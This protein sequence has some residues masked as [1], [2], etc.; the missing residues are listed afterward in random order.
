MYKINT[1]NPISLLLSFSGVMSK[2]LNVAPVFFS[3][4]FFLKETQQNRLSTF[5]KSELRQGVKGSRLWQMW[6]QTHLAAAAARE[7]GRSWWVGGGG[8]GGAMKWS[9]RGWQMSAQAVGLIDI[10]ASFALLV[11]RQPELTR[12]SLPLRNTSQMTDLL[13]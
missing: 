12:G 10:A 7:Q 13:Q 4:F 6:R 5:T 2:M 9:N 1:L 11:L 3:F 8:G